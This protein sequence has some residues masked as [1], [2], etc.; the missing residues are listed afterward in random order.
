MRL[1]DIDFKEMNKDQ[2]VKQII[3]DIRD[4]EKLKIALENVWGVFHIASFGMSGKAM[5]NQ[6]KVYEINVNGTKNLVKACLEN[7]INKLIYTSSY[8]V[9][10]GGQK[11]SKGDLKM[12]YFPIEKQIDY[13]SITKTISEK[14]VLETNDKEIAFGKKFKTI[15]LRPAG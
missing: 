3:L 6:S 4:F 14:F 11:I 2:R 9:V 13:Y 7:Q 12:D 1:I 15:S 5:L 10:F 8:N